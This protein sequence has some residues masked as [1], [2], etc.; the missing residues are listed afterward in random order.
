MKLA[1]VITILVVIAS[2]SHQQSPTKPP[3]NT[4]VLSEFRAKLQQSILEVLDDLNKKGEKHTTT[5]VKE[6]IQ[7]AVREV[8]HSQTHYKDITLDEFGKISQLI[9]ETPEY[10]AK[11][12]SL[13][14]PDENGVAPSLSLPSMLVS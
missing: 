13:L 12:K 2:S 5:E 11:V 1:A 8:I 6:K 14:K 4:A 7:Q 10:K 9:S 3:S